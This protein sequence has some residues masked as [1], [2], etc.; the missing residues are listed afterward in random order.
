MGK[1]ESEKIR[2]LKEE[3]YRLRKENEMKK[4]Q[5]TQRKKL[6]RNCSNIKI[7]IYGFVWQDSKTM[8]GTESR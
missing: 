8:E 2:K 5:I 7:V 4:E 3:N 1:S 6:L